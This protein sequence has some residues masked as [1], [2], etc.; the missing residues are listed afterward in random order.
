[1]PG[2]IPDR[3]PVRFTWE[4]QR[5]VEDPARNMIRVGNVAE[6]HP[7]AN[8]FVLMMAP[9]NGSPYR[10]NGKEP[11]QR[12]DQHKRQHNGPLSPPEVFH[13][14]RTYVPEHSGLGAVPR[15]ENGEEEYF[16]ALIKEPN[17]DYET[18]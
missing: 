4:A 10:A 5:F 3:T 7:R 2:D 6:I 18:R 1:L 13:L 8:R 16:S 9:V 17:P 12:H 15:D 14:L 11:G